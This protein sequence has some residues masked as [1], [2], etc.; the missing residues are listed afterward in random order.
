[1]E[2][3]PDFHLF[4]RPVPTPLRRL[5]AR[6]ETQLDV[7]AAVLRVVQGD[8]C[9]LDDVA[10]RHLVEAFEPLAGR[11]DLVADALDLAVDLEEQGEQ[12]RLGEADL[13]RCLGQTGERANITTVRFNAATLAIMN[14]YEPAAPPRAGDR[15]KIVITG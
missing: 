6:P 14:D 15:L 11:V 9:V 1:M 2:S 4:D 7:L 12:V 3:S 8:R 13:S 10:R 5:V